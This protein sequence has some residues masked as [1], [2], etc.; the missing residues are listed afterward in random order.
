MG[1]RFRALGSLP[2]LIAHGEHACRS[3]WR[4]KGVLSHGLWLLW[5]AGINNEDPLSAAA[6]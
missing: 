1:N 2:E 3:Q 4:V 6:T 5:V